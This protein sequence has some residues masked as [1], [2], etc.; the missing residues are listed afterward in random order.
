VVSSHQ[1]G[2]GFNDA[3]AALER[4]PGEAG[5]NDLRTDLVPQLQLLLT[6]GLPDIPLVVADVADRVAEALK[7]SPP[8]GIPIPSD[9]DWSFGPVTAS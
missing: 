6:E 4:L 5:E 7:E 8:P 1:T 9:D 2:A 3:V